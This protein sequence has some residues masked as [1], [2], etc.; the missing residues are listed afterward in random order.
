MNSS[1]YPL[2]QLCESTT[3]LQLNGGSGTLAFLCKG[4][5]YGFIGGPQTA[6]FSLK[7]SLRWHRSVQSG[8]GRGKGWGGAYVSMPGPDKPVDLDQS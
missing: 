3:R 6:T 2:Q 7:G 5:K 1:L 4:D 8:K